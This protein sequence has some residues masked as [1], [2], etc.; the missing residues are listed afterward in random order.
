[1]GCED[2]NSHLSCLPDE[3]YGTIYLAER[4]DYVG[5]GFLWLDYSGRKHLLSTIEDH[6][7][8]LI[9]F[10]QD[11]ERGLIRSAMYKHGDVIDQLVAYDYDERSNLIRVRDRFGKSIEF[12][13]D[14]ANRVVL[15]RN[16]NNMTYTWEYDAEGR[17][18]HTTGEGGV[19]EGY[20]SYHDGY[21][22]VRYSATGATE[23]YYYDD[24]NLVYKK[25]DAMG[26]ETWYGYNSW[27]ERTLV[28]TPEGKVIGYDYDDRGNLIKLTAADGAE[29]VY[30]YDDHNRVIARTDVAGNREEWVYDAETA[31]LLKHKEADGTVVTYTYEKDKQ[32]PSAIEYGE[33]LRAVLQYDTLGLISNITDGHGVCETFAYDDYGR[34]LKHRHAD[35]NSTEWQR[36]RL[37]RVTRY[38][39]PGQSVM[40]ISYDAYDLPVE[41]TSGN[42]LWTME[43]TPMGNLRRQTRRTSSMRMVSA[44]NYEY[45][46]YD[47]L[48][49]V[50]NE[51][52]ER[53]FFERDLNGEIIC[54]RG[55]DG[56]ERHYIRDLDGTVITTQLPDGTTVH[57]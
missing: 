12:E 25:V 33:E 24:N 21:N 48:K 54:E 56:A 57:H 20:I 4:I 14:N 53:Y 50:E 27:H 32:Q 17:V 7:G 41:V 16:R 55:F 40:R 36:D 29:T 39:T 38:A 28:G 47:Q 49:F 52:G 26:G 35:G 51:H 42:E 19:Q 22:E 8:R 3:E 43:Y 6:L 23:Q 1:M 30:E 15:R 18:I 11:E 45:D 13:H 34:P 37:G 44:L 46:S 9:I 10:G 5:G 2:R 31:L